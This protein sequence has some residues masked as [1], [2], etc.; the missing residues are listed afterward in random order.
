MWAPLS[1]GEPLRGGPVP[2]KQRWGG[3]EQRDTV[4]SLAEPHT[5]TCWSTASESVYV[6]SLQSLNAQGESQPVYRA[7]LTK[8]KISGRCRASHMPVWCV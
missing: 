7:A 5:L 8:R 6:V 4:T 3:R 1:T 2:R